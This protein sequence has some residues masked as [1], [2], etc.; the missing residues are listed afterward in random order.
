MNDGY[1]GDDAYEFVEVTGSSKTGICN[2]RG[3]Y[4][5]PKNYVMTK[6]SHSSKC[7]NE[8]WPKYD[9]KQLSGS[10]TV[11]G[12]LDAV[13]YSVINNGW[14]ISKIRSTS[15]SS[16]QFYNS[17]RPGVEFRKAANNM[18]MCV[19]NSVSFPSGYVVTEVDNESTC[20]GGLGYT[21][22][23]LSKSSAVTVCDVVDFTV[24][25]GYIIQSASGSIAKCGAGS[26]SGPGFTIGGIPSGSGKFT[27]C[28]K[29]ASNIPT[30][31]VVV[32]K[33]G[34]HS[35]IQCAGGYK[36][37]TIQR[38]K[39]G[40]ASC[41]VAIG[42]PIVP[43]GYAIN[44]IWS[45][46]SACNGG[47]AYVLK[48]LP[49]GTSSLFVCDVPG[50]PISSSY[51]YTS[52]QANSSAC[53]TNGAAS[54]GRYD[55][56]TITQI[57]GNGPFWICALSVGSGLSNPD[58]WV[59][60][61]V[62]SQ[63]QCT[64][65][66]KLAYKIEKPA[67]DGSET[68]TCIVPEFSI[69]NGF[70]SIDVGSYSACDGVLGSPGR[71]IKAPSSGDVVCAGTPIPTGYVFTQ[72]EHYS[73]CGGPSGLPNGYVL[74]QEVVGQKYISCSI[75]L[76]PPAFL[77]VGIIDNFHD[78]ASNQAFEMELPRPG[79]L[80]CGALK[81]P[82]NDYIVTSVIST[83]SCGSVVPS[84]WEINYPSDGAIVCDVIPGGT[85]VPD[86]YFKDASYSNYQGCG[87]ANAFR[88]QALSLIIIEEFVLPSEP[89]G[90]TTAPDV[91]CNTSNGTT[92]FISSV[93][94]NIST[95]TQP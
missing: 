86:G 90:S 59:V 81:A 46:Q 1:F 15:S 36:Q 49:T 14:V 5:M 32:G 74:E 68:R 30:G 91:I 47:D 45:D 38:V 20:D 19:N 94:K 48:P 65:A 61:K 3:L 76:L 54:G 25:G 95:C 13:H 40:I 42:S 82:T 79:L 88:L 26:A 75:G 18:V 28:A 89:N 62:S 58:G 60:T 69:P 51:V 78:C 64:G 67:T 11:Y 31:F 52:F 27:V 2:P 7:G 17:S 66:G 50:Y 43:S 10:S 57:S 41:E 56:A 63:S 9:I 71:T 8:V 70:I 37:W 21:L 24:P 33:S 85:P 44:A 80:V 4:S 83:S 55:G 84:F 6:N 93:S 22:A 73:Q 23:T 87:G 34:Q 77:V 16:C 92:A 53:D 12:C 39:S 29:N 35:S 72:F